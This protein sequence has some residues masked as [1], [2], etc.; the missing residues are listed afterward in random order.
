MGRAAPCRHRCARFPAARLGAPPAA[1]LYIA[2]VARHALAARLRLWCEGS[3][4]RGIFQVNSGLRGGESCVFSGREAGHGA[5]ASGSCPQAAGGA[6][7][8]ALRCGGAVPP[9]ERGLLV[10]ALPR[11]A[12]GTRGNGH[13]YSL[14]LTFMEVLKGEKILQF[15]DGCLSC[16]LLLSNNLSLQ[17]CCFFSCTETVNF[18][19]IILSLCNT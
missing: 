4:W 15:C 14:F 9:G 16:V 2:T 19:G 8:G 3:P 12:S 17:A 13:F 5:A 1:M 11:A 10:I 6:E 18:W 7:R